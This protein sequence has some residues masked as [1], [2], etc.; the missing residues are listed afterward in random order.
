MRDVVYPILL[1]ALCALCLSGC[2]GERHPESKSE[3][4]RQKSATE[5]TAES[6]EL[7]QKHLLADLAIDFENYTASGRC[8]ITAV[9]LRDDTHGFRLHSRDT[10][11]DHVLVNGRRMNF[12]LDADAGIL[13][14][15]LDR[16]YNR[17]ETMRI[18]I[19]YTTRP[20]KGMYI[21]RPTAEHPEIPLQMWTKAEDLRNFRSDTRYWLPC[22]DLPDDRVTSEIILT[23]PG[24]LTVVSN[25]GPVAEPE[26]LPDGRKR[27]HW[28]FDHEHATYLIAVD[29]GRF[30]VVKQSVDGCDYGYFV[31][32]GWGAQVETIFGRTPA[33]LKFFEDYTGCPYPY[34]KYDQVVVHDFVSGGMEHTT[35]TTLTTRCLTDARG[36]LDYQPDGL[37]AHE[38]AHMWFGDYVTCEH[39]KHI[40]QNEGFASYFT[41]LWFEHA[42]GA[43]EYRIRMAQTIR[44]Y[45]DNLDY[46][47]DGVDF[48][49]DGERFPVEMQA[50]KA[51]S[52]GSAVLHMLRFVLGD[53]AFRA[54]VRRY[55]KEHGPGNVTS[56]DWRLA[57]EAEHGESLMWFFDEWYYKGV[58]CPHYNV[59]WS[60]LEA[61]KQ[62]ALRVR[63]VQRTG[64]RYPV[65][66]MPVDVEIDAGGEKAVHRV[67]V[68]Q[69]D[70]TFVLPAAA[71]P[72]M[73]IFDKGGWLLAK[74]T[75]EKDQDDWAYQLRHGDAL[76][77]LQA[78]RELN[79]FGERVLAGLATAAAGDANAKVRV[80]AARGLEAAQRGPMLNKLFHDLTGGSTRIR[81]MLGRE[82]DIKL[83]RELQA[84]LLLKPDCGALAGLAAAAR[85][86][87]RDV[88]AV[89]A[90]A[91][92]A[93]DAQP[94]REALALLLTDDSNEVRGR[95]AFSA[96]LLGGDGGVDL[97]LGLL[98]ESSRG[99]V[100]AEW[101]LRAL[102]LAEHPRAVEVAL[103][104]TRRPDDGLNAGSEVDAMNLLLRL[105]PDADD[106][107]AAV[108]Y[109]LGHPSHRTRAAALQ[110]VADQKWVELLPA[111]EARRAVEPMET[112]RDQADGVIKKLMAWSGVDAGEG[113]A[114]SKKD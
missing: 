11:I 104:W 84:L 10:E 64:G 69:K 4:L 19:K 24:E 22:Y 77:R 100:I 33:M 66:D 62:V 1:T 73:L 78:A 85:D 49:K 71:R 57:L 16:G 90:L 48:G 56:E 7:D 81:D 89:A 51:Y 63:Q 2:A 65:Y 13:S 74:V 86:E 43:D 95:A 9:P 58:G 99:N 88:R 34:S 8:V 80:E 60:W 30:D 32:P 42:E 59:T 37:I 55:L 36:Y 68:N 50:G 26:S 83:F 92:S 113:K 47:L 53:E 6:R 103:A 31:P 107:K 54:A 72:D 79:V 94:A 15:A 109:L 91:L 106:T 12:S 110:A 93:F 35:K 27:H 97:A 44:G 61:S 75:Y 45:A 40:T 111:V 52:K 82:A 14:V 39:F 5:L 101:V 96:T 23:V 114:G 18:E 3:P 17:D 67:R 70:Q 102:A 20:H 29:A 38:L 25:G 105:R 41:N 28:R 76:E 108:E 46:E 87:D 98:D 112:V 21:Y